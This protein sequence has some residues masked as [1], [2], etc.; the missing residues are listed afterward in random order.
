VP[1]RHALRR[2]LLLAAALAAPWPGSVLFA[3]RTARAQGPGQRPIPEDAEL[4]RLEIVVFPQ[5]LLD[6]R[7]VMLGP[8]TRI[9]DEQNMI[10]P[11]STVQG[12]Q[13][14]AFARGTMGEITRVWLVTDAEHREIAARITAARRAAQQ[15]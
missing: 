14:V 8:G 1:S 13:R 3:P 2:R 10:R 7:P 11:P 9:F 12:V 5:A 6:G 15:R 4:G